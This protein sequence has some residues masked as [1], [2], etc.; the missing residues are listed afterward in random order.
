MKKIFFPAV[1]AFVSQMAFSQYLIVGKDSISVK[2]YMKENKYGLETA[3]PD[4]SV[5]STVEFLLLQQLAKEKRADTMNYYTNAVNQRMSELRE[6]KFYPKAIVDPLLQDFVN[7]NKT[8]TQILLFIKEKKAEDK[9]DYKALYDQVKAGKMT[10]EDF[11]SKNGNPEASKPFYV[12]PGMLDYDLYQQVKSLPANSYTSFINKPN[13]VGFAKVTNTRPSLGYLIFGVLTFPN[14][15]NYETTKAKIYKE[16]ESGKKFQTVV[17]EFGSTEEERNSGGAV[18]GSPILPDEVYNAFKGQPKDFYTKQ[19]ILFGDKYFIFNI[20]NIEPYTLTDANT[21]FFQKEM[22]AT[23][24]GEELTSKLVDYL[25][26]KEK[27]T[28]TL[29]FADL[30]KSYQ[31]YIN[32]KNPKALLFSYGKNK[33]TY[34]DL[35]KAIDSQYKNLEQIPT[36][37]WADLLDYQAQQYIVGVYARNFED[38]PEVKPEVDELKKNLY[39]EYIFSEYLKNEVKNNP[40]LSTDYYNENKSKFVWEKRAESRAAVISDPKLVKEIEKEIK[41]PKKWEA[42]KTKFKNQVNDK[43]Q[44]LVH[45]E[46]GKIQESSDIFKKNNVPFKKGTFTTKISGRDVVV[47][48]DELFPEQQMTQAEAAEDMTDGVTEKLLQKTIAEQR[49]KTK[50]EIQPAFMAELNKN[51]KK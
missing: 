19:P 37:Q 48:I 33:V 12:K 40:K 5:N 21:R 4:K 27:F 11:L 31:S 43:N 45:F 20:Y 16:L 41:D 1:L 36:S 2:D 14:D 35:K 18:M 10:M 38:L 34:E 8:E 6:Q 44:V 46:E 9:T 29:D 7:S 28:E 39:S 24:Y 32:P 22:L 13:V 23:G 42:L 49:A 17:K 30:K 47:A 26:T 50:I 51:F 15:A 25:K 3:G